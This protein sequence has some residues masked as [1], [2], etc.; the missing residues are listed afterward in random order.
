MSIR[1]APNGLRYA[2]KG[3]AGAGVDSTCEQRK[4]EAS[5]PKVCIIMAIAQDALLARFCCARLSA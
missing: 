1:Q 4:L 5:V 3:Y 2:P